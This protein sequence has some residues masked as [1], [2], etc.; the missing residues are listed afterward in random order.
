MTCGVLRVGALKGEARKLVLIDL[1]GLIGIELNLQG[2][3]REI[4]E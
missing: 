2:Y 3:A 4:H 1:L